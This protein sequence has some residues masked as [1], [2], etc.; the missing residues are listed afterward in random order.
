MAKKSKKSETD[1]LFDAMAAHWEHV[2]RLY[3]EFEDKR[4]VMLLSLIHI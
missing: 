4:P 1:Y 3:K 2:V